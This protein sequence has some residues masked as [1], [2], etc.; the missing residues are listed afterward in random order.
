MCRL[1]PINVNKREFDDLSYIDG[2]TFYT[3]IKSIKLNVKQMKVLAIRAPFL[4]PIMGFHLPNHILAYLVFSRYSGE[5]TKY[6]K[7]NLE[8]AA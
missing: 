6:P 8:G 2:T 5:L 1:K 4:L 3:A 7:G